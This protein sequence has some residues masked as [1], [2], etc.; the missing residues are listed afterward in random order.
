MRSRQITALLLFVALGAIVCTSLVLRDTPR[1]SI[2]SF[3]RRSLAS[4][5]NLHDSLSASDES[6]DE[7]TPPSD[8][9]AHK[10]QA[11]QSQPQHPEPRPTSSL[12]F[13]SA[14]RVVAIG[15]VHGDLDAFVDAMQLAGAINSD[16]HWIGG[17][18]VVVQVGDQVD[19]GTSERSLFE[20]IATLELE[21]TAQGG[22]LHSLIGNHE[23][24]NAFGIFSYVS[25][26]SGFSDFDRFNDDAAPSDFVEASSGRAKAFGPGGQVAHTLASRFVT[27]VVGDTL[28]VHAGILPRHLEIGLP[29]INAITSDFLRGNTDLYDEVSQVLMQEHSP[30]W[31]RRW[32]SE[33]SEESC[34]ELADILKDVGASRMVIGHTVQ[35][36]GISS[37]CNGLLWRVDAGISAFYRPHTSGD[38]QV[39]VVESG[40]VKVLSRNSQIRDLA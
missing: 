31:T 16:L 17:D 21:A 25:A 37:D 34:V 32:G 12:Y 3:E 29:Y 5:S 2:S 10:P 33:V 15:D 39:L 14:K 22:A 11:G 30:V 23:L 4:N 24:L 20:L 27:L 28:F 8:V 9:A 1:L 19:R 26:P 36:D 18:M 38:L 6:S 13:P 35:R 40:S 7:V